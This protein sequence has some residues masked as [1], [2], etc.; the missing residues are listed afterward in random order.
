MKT[1]SMC[2][3]S[4]AVFL[5]LTSKRDSGAERVAALSLPITPYYRK[6]EWFIST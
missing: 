1:A 5:C 3:F 6:L 4:E 2:G